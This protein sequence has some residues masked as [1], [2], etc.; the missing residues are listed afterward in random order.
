ME[1]ETLRTS[2]LE[3]STPRAGDVAA[4]HE[5]CQDAAIQRF[6]TVPSPYLL[7]DAEAFVELAHGWWAEGSEATWAIRLEQRL[8]GMVGLTKLPSGAPEIGYWVSSSV[9]GRG[10][11]REAARAVIDWAFSP[12]H[13]ELARI[14]WRAVVGNVGSARVA[15]S[16]GF[17]YEGLLR[18]AH[19]NSLGRS[20]LWVAGLLRGDDRRPVSWPVG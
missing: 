20:D 3:L 13:P 4:I 9:R 15:R 1:P 19:V 17:R 12:A 2:R 14:E 8:V 16:L 6:T 18:Q 7:A 5:E 11:A 10:V